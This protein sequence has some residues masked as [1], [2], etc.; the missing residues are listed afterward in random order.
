MNYTEWA[1]ETCTCVLRYKY[2]PAK[3]DS[4]EN[5]V[6]HEH[7][8]RCDFHK[9][10]E[11]QELHDDIR[12]EQAQIQVAVKKIVELNPSFIIVDATGTPKLDA[13]KAFVGLDSDHN[14]VCSVDVA[15]KASLETA[16]KEVCEKDVTVI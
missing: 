10:I 9:S 7:V 11:S 15:D 2:D 14:L 13:N 16:L 6:E 5:R 4:P 8:T 3:G 12:Y 1:P